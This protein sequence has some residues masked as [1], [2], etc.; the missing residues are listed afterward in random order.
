MGVLLEKSVMGEYQVRHAFRIALQ[1]PEEFLP[2]REVIDFSRLIPT[3][4]PQVLR[5]AS[6]RALGHAEDPLNQLDYNPYIRD[7]WAIVAVELKA[8]AATLERR[9]AALFSGTDPYYRSNCQQPGQS[10]TQRMS[11]VLNDRHQQRR[12]VCS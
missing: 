3:R 1:E 2:H 7:E 12:L 6:N 10:A 9:F 8:L 4:L 5:D 11:T